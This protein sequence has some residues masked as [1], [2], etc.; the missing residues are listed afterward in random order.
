MEFTKSTTSEKIV[1]MPSKIF[2]THG[3]PSSLR[4]DN[5][6]QFTSEH[7]TKYL[8][9]NGIE[10]RRTTPLWPQAN[11]EIERHNRSILKRLRIAQAEGRNGKSEMDNFLMMYRSTP[12]STT[13]VSQTELLFRR[14]IRT[15]LPHLQEFSIEDEVRD[16][17]SERKEKGKVYADCQRNARE[18]QIREGD[19]VLLGKD[20]EKKLSTPYKQSPFTV[21]QKN[22]NGVLVEGD[23][24]Y[25]VQYR[26][27]VSHA[28]KYL[29]RDYDVLTGTTKSTDASEAQRATQRLSN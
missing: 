29:E 27:N 13:G 1:S 21:I 17:D 11:G 7:F 26:R 15:K 3:L 14:H 23:A 5:V 24:L 4:T 6:P 18:R 9:E 16:R 8:E 2:F 12:H 25:G 28:K 10:H 19:K 20:K 22:G